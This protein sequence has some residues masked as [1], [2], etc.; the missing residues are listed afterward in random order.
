V[1]DQNVWDPTGQL[2]FGNETQGGA[3]WLGT[4]YLA[5]VYCKKLDPTEVQKN[6][7]TGYAF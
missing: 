5:A 2:T 6:F 1:T 3:P 7:A 4:I